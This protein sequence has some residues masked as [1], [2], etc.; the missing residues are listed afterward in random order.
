MLLAELKQTSNTT[1]YKQITEKAF[2]EFGSDFVLDPNFIQLMDKKSAQ[3]QER[4][5]T[6]LNEFKKNLIK[7]SIKRAQTE[8]GDFHYD[9]GDLNSALRCYV[10]T[11]D[12][13]STSDDI[14][15]MCLNVI[16][17]SIEMGN[18]GHVSNYITKAEQ[19]PNLT[20]KAVIA[21]L[22]VCTALS[23]L[24]NKKYKLTARKFLEVTSDIGNYS[25]VMSNQDIAIYAGLC[26]LATFDRSEL[27]TKVIDNNSFKPFLI[28]APEIRQAINDFYESKYA[29]CLSTLDKLKT[30]LM[31]DYHLHE[32][33]VFLFEKIRQRALI[34]YFS[35]FNVVDMKTMATAFATSMEALEKEIAILI[36]E[37]AISAR[38]DSQNKVLIARTTDQRSATF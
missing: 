22:K 25:T 11:R 34:Q 15:Q 8:L 26:A 24:S 16:K 2:E 20:D 37:N 13:C 6:E 12:Y 1:L 33:V 10:R 7:P 21:R 19:T 38:I 18:Y 3:T 4:L 30:N 23:N 17:V 31:L 9:R 32:H 5:E 14:L 35:P 29:T 28:L 36:V 27:K